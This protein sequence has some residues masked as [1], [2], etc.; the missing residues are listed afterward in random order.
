MSICSSSQHRCGESAA[1]SQL[2]LSLNTD[3]S[4]DGEGVWTKNIPNSAL[5]Y[6]NLL[7]NG[8]L[9]FSLWFTEHGIGF[10]ESFGSHTPAKKPWADTPAATKSQHTTNPIITDF[11]N[12][13]HFTSWSYICQ[14]QLPNKNISPPE[15]PSTLSV[16]SSLCKVVSNLPGTAG[17]P[18]RHCSII[19]TNRIKKKK[20]ITEILTWKR[21]PLACSEGRTTQLLLLLWSHP[22]T[23]AGKTP[24]HIKCNPYA[25]GKACSS[26]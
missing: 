4:L 23:S 1:T 11:K 6:L 7:E 22:G 12:A 18:L 26:L 15:H 21:F 25:V 2:S 24:T 3:L 5:I 14:Y 9:C 16:F 10:G 13:R 17:S 8:T 19:S 20:K